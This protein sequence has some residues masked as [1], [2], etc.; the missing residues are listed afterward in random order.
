MVIVAYIA[1]KK[2]Y[3]IPYNLKRIL[4][5]FLSAV[6]LYL[7]SDLLL[8]DSSLIVKLSL[9]TLILLGYLGIAYIF[10]KSKNKSTQ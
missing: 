2:H 5:Y 10:E 9:N 3:P 1:G 4:G 7:I 6:M 8:S